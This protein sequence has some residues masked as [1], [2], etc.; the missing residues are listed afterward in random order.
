MLSDTTLS[1]IAIEK[2]V[3]RSESGV[4]KH[5]HH[6]KRTPMS[7]IADLITA[8][9]HADAVVRQTARGIE[10]SCRAGRRRSVLR[11]A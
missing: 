11:G 5:N 10:G 6:P 1:T 7:T 2:G 9:K 3:A 4:A 8:H